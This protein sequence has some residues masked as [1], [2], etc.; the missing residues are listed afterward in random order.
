MGL[1]GTVRGG[2]VCCSR[3]MPGSA[4]V[5]TPGVLIAQSFK[6]IA[7]YVCA[8]HIKGA[9]AVLADKVFFSLVCILEH[10]GH[11]RLLCKGGIMFVMAAGV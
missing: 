3:W 5:A 4:G 1:H 2:I 9:H 11:F 7:C 10:D 8:L 6:G